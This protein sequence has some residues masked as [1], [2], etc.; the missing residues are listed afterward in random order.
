[1]HARRGD[2]LINVDSAGTVSGPVRL[3]DGGGVTGDEGV[4]EG[5]KGRAAFLQE[6]LKNT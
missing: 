2:E 5:E 6:C 1:M 3:R 4:K